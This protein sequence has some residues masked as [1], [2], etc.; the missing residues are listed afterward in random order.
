MEAF[1]EDPRS[2]D[3]F[4]HLFSAVGG[5][6]VAGIPATDLEHNKEEAQNP[7]IMC[8]CRQARFLGSV[9]LRATSVSAACYYPCYDHSVAALLRSVTKGA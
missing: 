9:A 3:D 6:P 5:N 1:E 4:R 8:L 7:D 2:L